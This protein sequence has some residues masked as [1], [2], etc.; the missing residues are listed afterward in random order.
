[1]DRWMD[2][3]TG[4]RTY[5]DV[6]STCALLLAS[7]GCGGAVVDARDATINSQRILRELI[8]KR[9]V[10][11]HFLVI[12]KQVDVLERSSLWT[13]GFQTEK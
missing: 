13:F 12:F 5:V 1:M 8:L 2:G 11:H 10:Q 9:D 3:W 6:I 4:G 7:E